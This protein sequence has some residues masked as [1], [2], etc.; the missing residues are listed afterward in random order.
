VAG[1]IDVTVLDPSTNVIALPPSSWS[2][3]SARNSV[4]LLDYVP[5]VLATVR[6]RYQTR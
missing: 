1:T 4:A 6:V 3:D 5:E 2:H